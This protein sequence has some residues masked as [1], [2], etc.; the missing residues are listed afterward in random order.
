MSEEVWVPVTLI[1]SGYEVS[2]HGR[3]RNSNT[4]RILKPF[5]GYGKDGKYYRKVH[6]YHN[7]RRYCQFVHRL[8]AFAFYEI[9]HKDRCRD[10]NHLS[11]LE[12]V[13]RKENDAR[14]RTYEEVPF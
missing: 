5:R 2:N 3:V 1:P 12:P 14:W 8:V 10:N 11:N 4:G 9:D 7:G 6:L 13:L